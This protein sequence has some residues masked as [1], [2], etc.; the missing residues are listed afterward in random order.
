VSPSAVAP[1]PPPLEASEAEALDA[2]SRAVVAV[3]D[4]V[5]PSVASLRV[6]RR[7]RGGQVPSGAG[8][9]VALT[10]DGFLLTSA[11][12]VGRA[13]GG[14][15]T[16]DDGRE[17]RFEVVGRDPLS[18]LAV[19]RAEGSALEAASLGTAER[20]RVGQLVVAIGNPHG[21]G[22]S[23]TA[24]VVSALG[25]SLPART[26]RG[27]RIIDN[28]I[29][30][31]AALNPGSSGGALAD[32]RGR[33]IGINTAVAGVGLGLAVPI[34]D[35]TQRVISELMRDGR[36]RR[37]YIGVA[38][39]PRPVPPQA[40]AAAGTATCIEVVEVVAG[41]PADHAGLRPEDL[42]LAVNGAATARV[43]DLQR[44]MVADLIGVPVDVRVLRAG[45]PLELELV[46]TELD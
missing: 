45:R 7:V 21:L 22:G 6:M 37:A 13:R 31:D 28:V 18:D 2:Y 11:H 39:G 26:R 44:L 46:P 30:T 12:V 9:A 27:G 16:F 42:I 4:R 8:S 3:A 32:S 10:P 40:R 14:R 35:A 36:V 17:E 34:N 25:R 38:G 1:Q 29:Q 43:E 23:V 41:S 5:G 24:G 20:L 19:L 33:V 15:A